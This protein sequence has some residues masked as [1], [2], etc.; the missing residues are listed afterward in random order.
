MVYAL[1]LADVGEWFQDR[2]VDGVLDRR[3]GHAAGAVLS[4]PRQVPLALCE[5]VVL[6]HALSEPFA[7][8]MALM[9]ATSY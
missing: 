1:R 5:L 7:H 9:E 6:G 4:L 3:R 2:R 8:Y